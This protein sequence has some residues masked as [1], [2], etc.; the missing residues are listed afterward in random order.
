VSRHAKRLAL[1]PERFAAI[2]GA[3]TSFDQPHWPPRRP[4]TADRLLVA[5]A[6]DKRISP[7]KRPRRRRMGPFL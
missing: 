5:R 6:R 7:R 2:Y 1:T 4:L 3:W